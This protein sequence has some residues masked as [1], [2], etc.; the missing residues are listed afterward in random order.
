M[1]QAREQDGEPPVLAFVDMLD[2][3]PDHA[4]EVSFAPYK[5]QYTEVTYHLAFLGCW[6]QIDMLA[7]MPAALYACFEIANGRTKG[8]LL[9]T[10]VNLHDAVSLQANCLDSPIQMICLA[11]HIMIQIVK[12]FTFVLCLPAPAANSQQLSI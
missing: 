8:S 9:A 12:T 2:Y 6:I 5:L 4:Y 1:L 7:R 11:K 3:D 10:H